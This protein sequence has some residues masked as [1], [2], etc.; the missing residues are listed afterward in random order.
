MLIS[1]FQFFFHIE[2]YS[3][4]LFSKVILNK[5]SVQNVIKHTNDF[6]YIKIEVILYSLSSY[7]QIHK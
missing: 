2:K 7:Y 3:K 1:Q 6:F 5:R 4:I